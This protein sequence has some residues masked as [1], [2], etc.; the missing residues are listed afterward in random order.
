M[1]CAASRVL[2]AAVNRLR[3][4]LQDSEGTN[5][6][7]AAAVRPLRAQDGPDAGTACRLCPSPLFFFYTVVKIEGE[8]DIFLTNLFFFLSGR[9]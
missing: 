4:L 9:R 3:R 6:T 1:T 2:C 7:R 8:V 5:R